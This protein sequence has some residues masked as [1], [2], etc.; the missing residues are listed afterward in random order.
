MKSIL[1]GVTLG[2]TGRVDVHEPVVAETD[3][4][5]HKQVWE[6]AIQT[7]AAH[8]CVNLHMTDWVAAQHEDPVPKAMI[9]WIPNQKVLDL[10]HL[11]RDSTN[12]EEGM[13]VL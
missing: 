2:L 3:E 8:M 5:I 7:T 10:K 4:D 9:D 6:A 11:L 1:D 13:A 12:T